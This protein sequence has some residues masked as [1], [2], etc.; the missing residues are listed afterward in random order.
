MQELTEQEAAIYDRQLRVAKNIV[1]AG[2]GSVTLVDDTPCERRAPG[3]FL[4]PA[5]AQPDQTVAEACAATLREMNPFV[6]L[7]AL[8][9]PIAAALTQHQLKQHDLVLL[10]GQPAYLVS[11]A[12]RLCT[13]AGVA[14]YA[15]T[16]RGISGWAFANL[17]D[18]ECIVETSKEQP[19]GTTAKVSKQHRAKFAAWDEAMSCSLQGRSFRRSNKLYFVLRACAELESEHGRAVAAAD[20]PQL[21]DLLQRLCQSQKL[22]YAKLVDEQLLEA[23]TT[24]PDEMPAI[25]A[26]VGGIL[27]NDVLKAVSKKGEPIRNLFMYSL[28]D[29]VAAMG[30]APIRLREVIYTLSP[31][32]QSVMSGLWKDLPHKA[33]HYADVVRDAVIFGFLPLYA[34]GKYCENYKEKEKQHHRY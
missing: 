17:H 15:A 1:L 24:C 25:N 27:A 4:I 2:V 19:D 20:L 28:A 8:G 9:G 33:S 7:A 34:V 6:Q 11:R 5:D 29:G 10:C 22:D 16:C 13:E 26:I 21:G 14:F 31:F 3:N 23:F 30:K 32:Q 12:D 18:Y